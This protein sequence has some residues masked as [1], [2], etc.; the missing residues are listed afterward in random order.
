MRDLIA[1]L[2]DAIPADHAHAGITANPTGETTPPVWVLGSS[3]QSALY[4]AHFG[5]PFSFA[6]F[7][8]PEGGPAVVEAYRKY[9]KPSAL[10][11]KPLANIGV[12]VL[13]A[14]TEEKARY[15]SASRDLWV[16]KLRT[17]GNPG[18]IPSAE[19]AA[20]F[21]YSD[22]QRALVR[23]LGRRSIVG[24]PEQVKE[25]VTRLTQN[26]GIDECVCLTITYDFAERLRSYELLA[27]AFDL[28]LQAAA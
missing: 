13:C 25:G 16:M 10:H 11:D 17:T 8:S 20:N 26:Y 6:H 14:E 18:Q 12:S 4:A 27:Q 21:P 5:L 28:K 7:I 3:E 15:L 9:F 22:E 23:S 2:H 19:E 1:F 24:T